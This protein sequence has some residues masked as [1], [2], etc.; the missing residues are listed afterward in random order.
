MIMNSNHAATSTFQRN[1][2]F[3]FHRHRKPL[4]GSGRSFPYP[5]AD[6]DVVVGHYDNRKHRQP[7]N[8]EPN[9]ALR[10]ATG[11]DRLHVHVR[12]QK[13]SNQSIWLSLTCAHNKHTSQVNVCM[14]SFI[15]YNIL[16]IGIA[17]LKRCGLIAGLSCGS[18]GANKPVVA[19][20]KLGV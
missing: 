6:V 17:A 20:S 4:L 2:R 3:R 8:G 19:S 10:K 13:L 11:Q 16:L 1:W 9:S 5:T 12:R 7:I 14:H 15:C 18:L